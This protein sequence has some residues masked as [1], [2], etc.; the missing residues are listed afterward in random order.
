MI[1]LLPR[2]NDSGVLPPAPDGS[3]YLCSRDEVEQHFVINFGDALW[4]RTLFDGWDLLRSSIA[5]LVPN[6]RWWLWGSL[7]TATPEP[8]FGDRAF[9][10]GVVL[11]DL[12]DL[13]RD[14]PAR[15][16]LAGSVFSAEQLHQVD[17]SLWVGYPTHD[18]RRRAADDDLRNW[19]HQ[20]SRAIVD[21]QSRE[22][23]PAGYIEVQP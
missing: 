12:A 10:R 22:M 15:N 19:R 14:S 2:F 23:I 11:I 20:A 5:Q 3:P 16:L 4:R 7:I 13:P 8:L 9:T 1:T 17:A 21:L 18:P 6:A